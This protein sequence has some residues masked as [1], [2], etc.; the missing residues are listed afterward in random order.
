MGWLRHP[1]TTQERR[2]WFSD[3][4]L[5]AEYP[6]LKLRNARSA[7]NLP[8]LYDDIAKDAWRDR[9]WKRHRDTQYGVVRSDKPKRKGTRGTFNTK[10]VEMSCYPF[11]LMGLRWYRG[12]GRGK[13]DKFPFRV[14]FKYIK[15]KTA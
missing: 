4:E 13:L 1:K 10:D 9:S 11:R 15:N 12:V 6:E 8:T 3:I 5:I 7:R 2:R 14:R